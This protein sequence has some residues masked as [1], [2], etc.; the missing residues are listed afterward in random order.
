MN[1]TPS[2]RIALAA[3]ALALAATAASAQEGPREPRTFTPPPPSATSTGVP[4]PAAGT[5]V[6]EVKELSEPPLLRG[7]RLETRDA[8]H[9]DQIALVG[10]E[11]TDKRYRPDLDLKRSPLAAKAAKSEGDL[12]A[13]QL[14]AYSG[15]VVTSHLPEVAPKLNV[16]ATLAAGASGLA[17]ETGPWWAVT[18]VGTI[19]FSILL[20]RRKL[21]RR[22]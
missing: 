10:L 5:R 21:T 12:H 2:R 8:L 9:P 15:G 11:Q 20:V 4:A 3:V 18:T 17:G 19:A 22:T 14:A 7:C 16:R 6:A 1:P 13:R